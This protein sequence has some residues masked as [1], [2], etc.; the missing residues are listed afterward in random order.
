MS[1]FIPSST[2]SLN[3]STLVTPFA[4]SVSATEGKLND[5]ISTYGND[6]TTADLL[7]LQ[8]VVTQY[9]LMISTESTLIKD[10]GDS[11]K[12]IVQRFS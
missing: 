10:L 6:P 7:N 12:G 9:S 11:L 1:T 5:L 3:F 8:T 2:S 4:T